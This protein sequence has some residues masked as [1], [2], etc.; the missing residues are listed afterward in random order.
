MRSTGDHFETK[1][2]HESL[3]LT[4]DAAEFNIYTF[5]MPF[6]H[7]GNGGFQHIGIE[8]ATKS[9][10]GRYNDVTDT[11]YFI[12][13]DQKWMMVFWVGMG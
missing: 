10:I 8:A 12:M 9:A 4:A 6:F 1:A 13:L 2:F 5:F 7:I 11:F 3:S